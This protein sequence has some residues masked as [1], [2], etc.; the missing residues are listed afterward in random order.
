MSEQKGTDRTWVLTALFV[1]AMIVLVCMQ[2]RGCYE[3]AAKED[4][5]VRTSQCCVD[6][7]VCIRHQK[8]HEAHLEEKTDVR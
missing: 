3:A 1:C 6:L 4:E 7:A 5:A 2:F 8:L